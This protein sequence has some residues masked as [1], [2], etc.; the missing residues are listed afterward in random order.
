MP[1]GVVMLL[2]ACASGAVVSAANSTSRVP[3]ESPA[4]KRGDFDPAA[5]SSRGELEKLRFV[6]EV[7]ESRD[8]SLENF[9]CKVQQ[10]TTNFRVRDGG[11]RHF[12]HRQDW[13]LRRLGPKYWLKRIDYEYYR[14]DLAVRQ[15]WLSSWD[16]SASRSMPATEAPKAEHFCHIRPVENHDAIY[17]HYNELLGFRTYAGN[18]RVAALIDFLRDAAKPDRELRI[19]DEQVKDMHAIHMRVREGDDRWDFWL[20]PARGYLVERSEWKSEHGAAYN[21]VSGEL[22]AAEQVAGVWVPRKVVCV[23][24][25]SASEEA[26][27]MTYEA[28]SVRIGHVTEQDVRLTIPKDA[29]VFDTVRKIAYEPLAN[30]KYRLLP[31]E[32]E[33]RVLHVPPRDAIV[34][35]IDDETPGLYSISQDL[36]LRLRG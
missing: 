13:E 12:L 30:G 25:T 8:R 19:W 21:S 22:R 33:H 36:P 26:T 3:A 2:F 10:S 29:R 20:D 9:S 17:D 6:L 14:P 23:S 24:G 18:D 15:A 34:D 27:E 16:G 11:G 7:L 31:I 32:D 1:I 28:T 4:V 5:F 35:R